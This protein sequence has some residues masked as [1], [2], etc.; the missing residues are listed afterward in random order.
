VS[1]SIE[2]FGAAVESL[3]I[4]YGTSVVGK[5]HLEMFWNILQI[6]P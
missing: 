2:E 1:E 3:L 6:L 4:R 5:Q